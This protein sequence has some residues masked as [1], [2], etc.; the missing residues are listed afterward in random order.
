MAQLVVG[1]IIFNVTIAKPMLSPWPWSAQ[2]EL[3]HVR[4]QGCE[5]QVKIFQAIT[6][7]LTSTVLL[8]WTTGLSIVAR[9]PGLAVYLISIIMSNVLINMELLIHR[10]LFQN[11]FLSINN[12]SLNFCWLECVSR[13]NF[14][15][16][17]AKISNNLDE[18][19]SNFWLRVV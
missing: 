7:F 15:G 3:E 9:S 1:K 11:I 16:R 2:P 17:A 18:L 8:G 6:H 4:A 14:H 13:L 12:Y 19:I 5:F 10:F